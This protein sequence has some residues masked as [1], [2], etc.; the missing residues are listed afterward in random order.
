M[1]KDYI[2]KTLIVYEQDGNADP[3]K[4]ELS[5]DVEVKSVKVGP[6]TEITY[7][8]EAG[9]KEL[10]VSDI[11]AIL[12]DKG[13]TD[14]SVNGYGEWSF[15]YDGMKFTE[16]DVVTTQVYAVSVKYSND[17]TVATSNVKLVAK[18]GVITVT[19]KNA[20]GSAFAGTYT[21]ADVK[22]AA[23]TVSNFEQAKDNKS[24]KFDFTFSGLD[25]DV[26][27]VVTLK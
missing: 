23:G 15:T 16:V 5:K 8:V 12:T 3:V 26:E 20:D 7:Y 6:T 21:G 27:L 2:V 13:C 17:S 1:V 19:V 14:I 22:G 25:K 9:E 11:K 4:P 18:N 24:A 10:S